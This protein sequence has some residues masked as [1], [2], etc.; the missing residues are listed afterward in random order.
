MSTNLLIFDT[1][2]DILGDQTNILKTEKNLFYESWI[3]DSKQKD[4]DK[5]TKR[6]S[7]GFM[8]WKNMTKI[9]NL[10]NLQLM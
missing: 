1:E 5:I 10:W 3:S 2:S 7:R 4:P 8:K 9:Q 6:S